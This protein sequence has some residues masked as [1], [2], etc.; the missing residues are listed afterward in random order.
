[1]AKKVTILDE[2]DG[3]TYVLE[4]NRESIKWAE[5]QGFRSDSTG[6]IDKTELFIRAAFRMHQPS[7]T[8][9]A[10]LAAWSHVNNKR[11][12]VNILFDMY[13]KPFED[14]LGTDDE[15]GEQAKNQ[16]WEVEE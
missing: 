5:S 2:V 15:D 4:F 3:K 6:D 16:N 1:M 13:N 7:M 8:K 14:L 12:L 11:E 10:V 9:G